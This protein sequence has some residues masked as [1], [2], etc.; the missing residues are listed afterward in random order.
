MRYK[1]ELLG[2][3]TPE[4][5]AAI[6]PRAGYH[7]RRFR[8]IFCAGYHDVPRLIRHEKL[9]HLTRQYADPEDAEQQALM[10]LYRAAWKYN[11]EKCSAKT[12]KPTKPITLC[13]LW[14]RAA[15][16]AGLR[17]Q[18]A[19]L[20]TRKYGVGVPPV[21][22]D[23]ELET[24]ASILSTIID[25]FECD[26]Q[27]R[28][29][30]TADAEKALRRMAEKDEQAVRLYAELGTYQAVAKVVG[31]SKEGVRQRVKSGRRAALDE[32]RKLFEVA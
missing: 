12:G 28:E 11:P 19:N 30:W 3:L 16:Q 23:S 31:I 18:S 25:P 5:I 15:L 1:R 29:Q 2:D 6:R 4:I 24:G 14:I 20:I 22:G 17:T 8:R 7:R 9:N 27:D 21:Y 10:G 13:F 32:S 26:R